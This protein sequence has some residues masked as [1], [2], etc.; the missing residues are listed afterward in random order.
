[1]RTASFDRR[2]VLN[3]QVNRQDRLG[4]VARIARIAGKVALVAISAMALL[5]GGAWAFVQTRWGGQAVRHFAL[6]RVNAQLA[7][8]LELGRFSFGGDHLTLSE[9]VL[10]DPSGAVVARVERI[11]VAFSRLAL[12]HRHL[13]VTRL[14]VVRPELWLVEDQDGLN[15]TRALAPRAPKPV[16]AGPPQSASGPG[17]IIDLRKLALTDG[18]IDFRSTSPDSSRHLRVAALAVAGSAHDDTGQSRVSLDLVIDAR[19]GHL[20]AR[21]DLDLLQ[22]R[23]L[24]PGLEV[25]ARELDLAQ[26]YEGA[27]SSALAFDLSARGGGRALTLL[28]GSL[29]FALP[30]GRLGGQTFGPI[31]LSA[32]AE[33]GLYTVADLLAVLPGVEVTGK[34][35]ATATAVDLHE[36]VDASD[37]GA[38]AQSLA[39]W[40]LAPPALSGRGRLDLALGGRLEAPSLRV[41]GEVPR[42]RVGA[43]S[44]ANL[45][46]TAS[47]PDLRSPQAAD[48]DLESSR[49]FL[50]GQTLRGLTLAI[51]AAGP[52]LTVNARTTAPFPLTL[53]V[54][55]RRGSPSSITIDALDLHTPEASW[56]LARQARLEFGG[57][58]FSLAGFAL[59]A[60]PERIEADLSQTAHGLR[61]RLIVE[62]LDLARLPHAFVPPALGV[63]G[64]VD[65]DARLAGSATDPRLDAK[66]SLA[67]GRFH[68]YRDLS[69]ALDAHYTAGR[70]RGHLDA[71][72]LGTAI[73]SRFDLPAAWPIRDRR[74]PLLLDLTLAETDIAGTM[75][76]LAIASGQAIPAHL[77][78]QAY[79]TARLDGTLQDPRLALAIGAKTLV[80]EGQAVGDVDLTLH[81]DG[82]RP[83]EG[84]LQVTTNGATGAH[85]TIDLKT[86]LSL[87]AALR[88][89]PTPDTLVRTPMEVRGDV[90]RLPLAVL[91]QLARHSSPVGGTLSSH[92]ALSG[93]ALDPRGSVTADVVGAT[94]Q[95]V[96]ATDAR[97]EIQ[98]D[99]RAIDLHLRVLRERHP[100]LALETHLGAGL[101]VLRDPALLADAPL[102]LRAVIGPLQLQRLGLP[103][104]DDRQ[105]PRVLKGRVHVDLALDGSLRAP[106]LL[107]HADANDI[108][109]D[110]SLVG[111]AHLEGTYADR[112]AKVE[113][114]LVSANQGVVH[115]AAV[116]TTNLG[117]PAITHGLDVRQLPLDV[118][119]D[120][121]RFDIQGLSGVTQE[122]RTVGGL[123]SASANGRGTVAD[124]RISGK[125]EWTNGLLAITGLG[126][127]HDI[128]L[129]VHGDDQKLVLDELAATSGNGTARVTGDAAHAAGGY[130]F[131]ARADGSRFPIYQEGQPLA[132]VSLSTTVTGTAAPFDTRAD[133]EID[134]ARIELSDG[135]RN[136]LQSLTSPADVVLVDA[137]QPLNKAQAERLRLLVASRPQPKG[138]PAP[139]KVPPPAA[140]ALVSAVRITVNAPRKI[141]VTGKD[142]NLE[143]GLGPGFRVSMTDRTRVVGQVVVK[144]GRIDILGRRFDLKADSTLEFNGSPDRPQLDVTAQYQNQLENVTV[145]L[146]AKGPLDH[147]AIAVTSPNRP[148]LTE[149]QLYTLI[150]TGHLQ[151]GGGTSGSSAPSAEAASF[152][153][154]VLA[155]K[156]QKTLAKKL[157]LDVFTVD[158]GDGQGLNGTQLEAGRYVAD[159]L[160]VGY[161]GRVDPNLY[162]NRNAVHVEYQLSSRWGVDGEYGDVGTG[163][164]DLTWKKNY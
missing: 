142:A 50:G 57:G 79:L 58:R 25:Q 158:A 56:A 53:A 108:R 100:L 19:G 155:A 38:L 64:M 88:R 48:V 138:G 11:E 103:P 92:L 129:A 94:A 157:P 24:G 137:G 119:I 63:G 122:L 160:Y 159:K 70:A 18:T 75:K 3:R 111:V 151:L 139:A 43:S 81:G 23:A 6:P 102:R 147:M 46:L 27:P 125:L 80:V 118:R 114:R 65:V 115:A 61:G 109:L 123:F 32:R 135:K 87:R 120:A 39:A 164:L 8:R 16:S 140:D 21:G 51:H 66:L 45:K 149:S 105:P 89:P 55:G 134:N 150:I 26:L 36:R 86:P 101:P 29:D 35:T 28:D 163:S 113:A 22:L 141:W 153:G 71:H 5:I 17:M 104:T 31:R 152:L 128:H 1:M 148:D 68:G 154:G 121:Q 161:V 47:V 12:L 60:G 59:R 2:S 143:I 136:N 10:H 15:L 116:T 91:A 96:P 74:A 132:Q 107:W 90:D 72:G 13:D 77:R 95:G 162:Q 127:Y 69:L 41:T 131:H 83:L 62:K 14:A 124:P 30:A 49:A 4:R 146:T 67:G 82:D 133:V 9:V 52:R 93:T 54:R 126:E 110:K 44:A 40:G 106:R 117:Y 73:S 156:L 34:G 20:A 112:Q 99:R 78:G 144:R 130:H 98:L 42:I 7:G 33:R 84:R 85:T 37:L 76:A 97:L 145:V